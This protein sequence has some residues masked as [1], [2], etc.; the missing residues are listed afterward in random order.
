MP[1]HCPRIVVVLIL[2]LGCHLARSA[3]AEDTPLGVHRLLFVKA[4]SKSYELWEITGSGATLNRL[5]SVPLGEFHGHMSAMAVSPDGQRVAISGEDRVAIHHLS[6]GKTRWVPAQVCAEGMA[7]RRDGTLFFSNGS[8]LS[9]L[10][11]GAEAPTRLW[12]TRNGS[13]DLQPRPTTEGRFLLFLSR[14]TQSPI[15]EWRLWRA[16]RTGK[17]RR[18][19]PED[20][21]PFDVVPYGD[22]AIYGAAVEA[23]GSLRSQL[24]AVD[25]KGD[26]KQLTSD[27][28][29][30]FK[31]ARGPGR[32]L[33]C[34]VN[35][36]G[37]QKHLYRLEQDGS[38]TQLTRTVDVHSRPVVS[39]CGRWVAILTVDPDLGLRALK[40]APAKGGEPSL[41]Y[42]F[43][44]E[45][46]PDDC[47]GWVPSDTP[48]AWVV[49]S[50]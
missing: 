48:F 9:S 14:T 45:P 20:R 46:C 8:Q 38:A 26:E 3:V 16:G 5:V 15:G 37:T 18:L 17:P 30:S 44:A 4:T 39:P 41:L 24:F 25:G 13:L 27:P 32:S 50:C 31:P 7:Y 2:L 43:P 28:W 42:T 6:T 33:Y 19:T 29:N 47:S 22:G 36:E 12:P 21:R 34:L 10:S 40:L 35:R 11:P 49:C 1:R 23:D